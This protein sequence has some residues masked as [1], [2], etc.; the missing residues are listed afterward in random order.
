MNFYR[1]KVIVITGAGSGIGR[2]LA[3]KLAPMAKALVMI[4]INGDNLNKVAGECQQLASKLT[5]YSLICDVRQI[6]AMK[7]NAQ[8]LADKNLVPDVIIAN[9][10]LGAVNPGPYFDIN[11]DRRL[12]EVNYFGTTNTIMAYLPFMLKRRAGNI[13]GVASLAGLRGLPLAASYSASKAAQI[14]LLESLRN[15]L[16]FYGI[17]VTTVLPGF[18]QTPMADHNEF[19]RPFMIT[20]EHC[21]EVIL[22]SGARGIRQKLF[23]WPMAMLSRLNRFLPP[24]LFDFLVPRLSKGTL[25]PEDSA[26]PAHVFGQK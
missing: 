22:D 19:D 25:H 24:W 6:E 18:I 3:L 16:K 14:S 12:M 26:R 15:D 13:I 21:A 5:I 9:A 1:E 2:T 17:K 20:A 11:V 8:K 4:D 7:E 23:P 10:G